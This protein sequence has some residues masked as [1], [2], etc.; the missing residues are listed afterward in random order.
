VEEKRLSI[1]TTNIDSKNKKI[2]QKILDAE[3]LDELKDLTALFNINNQKRN[4]LRILKMNNLLDDVTDNIIQRFEKNPHNFSNDDLL[5][6]LQVTENAIDRAT[7]NLNMVEET[8]AIQMM[9][10]N[11]VNININDGLDRESRLRVTDT[12]KQI[13]NKLSTMTDSDNSVIEI[14]PEDN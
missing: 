9:Q 6:Y 12:V 14:N 7:K 8:P 10:N 1:D 4:A 5:K 3:D 2:A 13:L 11:Q